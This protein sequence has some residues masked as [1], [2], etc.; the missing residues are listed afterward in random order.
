MP[1][2]N[3]LWSVFTRWNFRTNYNQNKHFPSSLS[4]GQKV[5][6]YGKTDRQSDCYWAQNLINGSE[7]LRKKVVCYRRPL[8]TIVLGMQL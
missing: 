5:T 6:C 8:K 4:L 2:I 1:E 7:E 3:T